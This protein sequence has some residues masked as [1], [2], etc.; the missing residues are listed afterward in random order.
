MNPA[1][2]NRYSL[3]SVMQAAEQIGF[4]PWY[5]YQKIYS[6][7]LACHR[8][9]GRVFIAQRDLDDYVARSRVAALGEKR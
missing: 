3:L 1:P 7:Q 4:T 9:G 8:I 5:V 6:R 2:N